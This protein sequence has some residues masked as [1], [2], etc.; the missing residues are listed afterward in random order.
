[1]S[2]NLAQ[3]L[4]A[5]SKAVGY[6]QKDSRNDF[7]KYNYLSASEL[8]RHIQP[9]LADEGVTLTVNYEVLQVGDK[10]NNNL[11]ILRGAYVFTDGTSTLSNVTIG[12][13]QDKNDKGANKAM[14]AAFKYMLQQVLLIP[15]GDDPDADERA[16]AKLRAEP[17]QEPSAKAK[18]WALV[19]EAFVGEPEGSDL[20]AVIRLA[21]RYG[22][23]PDP[24]RLSEAHWIAIAQR[25]AQLDVD[26]RRDELGG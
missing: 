21:Q 24:K 6:I 23:T 22:N 25:L 8:L 4:A 11:T 10:D 12:F 5:V 13:G 17:Q 19:Q 15:S 26:A 20:N 1:M 2:K 3:R 9:F 18:A 7:H 16:P 14:T